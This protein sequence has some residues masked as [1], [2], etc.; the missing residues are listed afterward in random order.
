MRPHTLTLQVSLLL[1]LLFSTIDALG[2]QR[3]PPTGGRIAVVVD[4]RLAALRSTPEL[5][6]NLVCRLGRGRPVRLGRGR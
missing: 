1:L 3:K 5:N 4:E 2:R 6:G